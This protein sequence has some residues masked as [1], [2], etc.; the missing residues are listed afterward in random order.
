MVER[1]RR[2]LGVEVDAGI[3]ELVPEDY[4][5]KLRIR[6][7]DAFPSGS[8]RLQSA[9]VP[10]LDK[11]ARV[12]DDRSGKIIVS[13]HTDNVPIRTSTYPSNWVLSSARAASVVHHLAEARLADP[14]RV[15]IRAYAQ[16]RPLVP[17]D[18]SASRATNRRVEIDIGV[19]GI[20]AFDIDPLDT[21]PRYAVPDE[22]DAP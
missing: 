21:A 2:A 18:S 9:F 8:A 16:T 4:G 10:V 22:V 7:E 17:N 14:A 5:V 6:D 15:E 3:V 13:G 11:L 1:L 19:E 20:D 12:L